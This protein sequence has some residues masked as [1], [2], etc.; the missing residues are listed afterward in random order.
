M[1]QSPTAGDVLL[2]EG[3]AALQLG[4]AFILHTTQH[5]AQSLVLLKMTH[6][7]IHS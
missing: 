1:Q 4:R 2:A 3:V 5:F 7:L 6:T